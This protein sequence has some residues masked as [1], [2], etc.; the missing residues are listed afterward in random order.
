MKLFFPVL[1]FLFFCT[2][3]LT[4]RNKGIANDHLLVMLKD[5]NSIPALTTE[6]AYLNGVRT[7]LQ[8]GET[9]SR[10][11]HI[12]SFRF[13]FQ[14]IVPEQLLNAVRQNPVVRLAQLDHAVSPRAV[15][16]DPNFSYLWN[17]QNTGQNNGIPGADIHAT[18]AWDLATGGLTADGDTIVIAV[19]DYGFDLSHPDLHFWKNYRE[20][21][22]NGIDDDHNGYTD[23][24]DGWNSFS[25][26][27]D[28]P[29]NDHGN[30]VCGIA[31]AKGNNG[32]G[33]TGVNWSV[34]LMPVS[35]G[36]TTGFE[37]NVIAAYAYVLEQRRLYNESKGSRGTFVV[38]TNSSFG[39]DSAKAADHPLWC[40]LYD[41]LG[42]QGI[43]SAGATN[44]YNNVNVDIGG[45][46]PTS[47]ESNW[48][49][50]VTNTSN[51]DEKADGAGYGPNSIDLGA[52]GTNIASTVLSGGYTFKS[53]TSMA[54]PHVSGAI[55]LMFSAACKDLLRRYKDDLPGIALLLKDSLLKGTDAIP[56]LM[57]KTT[58][59]GRLN[60]Y[61]SVV[62]VK[63]YCDPP[64]PPSSEDLFSILK[65]YPVPA[66]EELRIDY[67]SDIA[68]NI[69]ITSV[70]GQEVLSIPCMTN[71]KGI[72]Q[73]TQLN[74][75][76]ISQ[77]VYF[78]TLQGSN[79][80]TKSI[81]VIL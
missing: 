53:G 4:A 2:P 78:I 48:L 28:L 60:L 37:S 33:V 29:V 80:K 13:D 19:I 68:A 47:C 1:L 76:G 77:G 8:F 55:A 50:T 66:F 81:K 17:M 45:D 12:Y 56:T 65:I 18:E 3:L 30:H 36:G 15:P 67:T 6:L 38:T 26:T 10:R 34:Q 79:K 73:H 72:I 46:I 52:P 5:E 57:G 74:L 69:C 54:T 44:N 9:I 7:G 16:D 75:T 70:L 63:N 24:F 42:A 40:A 31:G 22:G 35:Y 43:L 14:H 32:L 20:I 39:I 25:A 64:Q 27:D 49:I 58:S 51:R 61:R 21:P 71:D 23:D 41:S 59:N 11:L 62:A